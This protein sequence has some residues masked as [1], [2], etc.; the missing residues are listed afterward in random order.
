MIEKWRHVASK[1]SVV[2]LDGFIGNIVF[3]SFF[4]RRRW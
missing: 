1:F 3:K 2:Q 4:C